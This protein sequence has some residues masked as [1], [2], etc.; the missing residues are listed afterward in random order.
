V[1]RGICPPDSGIEGIVQPLQLA[2]ARFGNPLFAKSSNR[3]LVRFV[4]FCNA[5]L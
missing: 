1:R 2:L 3:P 5:P 4:R